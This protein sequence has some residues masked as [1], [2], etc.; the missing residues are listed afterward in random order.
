MNNPF[1]RLFRARDE[2]RPMFIHTTTACGVAY[3]LIRPK[4]AGSLIWSRRFG[5]RWKWFTW[6]QFGFGLPE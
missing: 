4:A 2:P 1:M 6:R 5:G 3:S